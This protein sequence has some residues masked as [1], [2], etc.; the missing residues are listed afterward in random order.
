MTFEKDAAVQ[1]V[2]GFLRKIRVGGRFSHA[3]PSAAVPDSESVA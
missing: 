2:D 3:A 1:G